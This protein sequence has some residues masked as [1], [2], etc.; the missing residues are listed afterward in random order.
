FNI[1]MGYP[2]K[3]STLY[4]VFSFIFKAQETKKPDGYYAK[5]YLKALR[6][7]LVKNLRLVN[8]NPAITRVL[9]HKIEEVLSGIEKTEISGSLFVK[10]YNI[11]HCKDLYEL[12]MSTMKN[13]GIEAGYDELKKI[14]KELHQLLFLPWE[15]L[16]NFREF[17]L[18]LEASLKTL[19]EKSYL[20]EYPLNLK[21][22][23]RLF[24]LKDE[25]KDCAFSEENFSKEEI[26]KIFQHKLDNDV[27]SFAGSP[28]KG[29]QILGLQE[30]RALSF[31]NVIVL[32][33]NEGVL[34]NLKVT[35]PLIPREVMIRLG[36]NQ[37]EK[38]EEIQRYQFRRLLA[39]AKNV[40]L[41]Y[42][43]NEKKQRSRFIE[44]LLW[45]K[46]KEKK[47]IEVLDIKSPVFGVSFLPAAAEIKKN[48]EIIDFLRAK[49]YSASSVNTYLDCP[50]RFYFQYVLGLKEKD[51]LLDEPEGAAVG[52]FIHELLEGQFIRFKGKP[53]VIDKDFEGAF[54]D[55]FE[56]KFERD[57]S[58]RM[59]SDAFLIKEI[60]L[61]RLKRFLDNENKR[62]VAQVLELE[63]KFKGKIEL[64]KGIFKFEARIDRIDRLRDGSILVVDYK[65]GSLSA[66]RDVNRLGDFQMSRES[67]KQ[68]IKSF[69][70]FIYLYFVDK[71][72]PG[73][74]TNACLYS[75]R[76]MEKNQGILAM[77]KN[78]EDFANK[79]NIM[80]VYSR[81]IDAIFCE[82]LDPQLSFCADPEPSGKCAYCPFIYLCKK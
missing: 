58:R 33:L 81:A 25:F 59:R 78:E 56:K 34:P 66:P 4:S 70:L 67:L 46:Q 73:E 44:E 79:D 24:D 15:G 47:D 53:P 48:A 55:A 60:M 40:H 3:R 2:L 8:Q 29:L 13:M 76:D 22:M 41:I 30:T 26:F 11:E 5:D 63:K 82:L 65:T 74:K 54:W 18:C 23:Q 80:S 7:P 68:K 36:L 77:F 64:D 69:Q 14:V 71:K 39:S 6:H 61:F 20:K 37:L 45:E 43:E 62:K 57:F 50:M 1:S 35:E 21:I 10:L 16:A 31:E 19:S 72:Y 17:A 38:E 27:V 28:L 52:T 12:A 51:D 49:T 32:D 75:L 42:E 9:V